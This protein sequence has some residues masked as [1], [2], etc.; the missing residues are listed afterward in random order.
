MTELSL[1]QQ[2]QHFIETKPDRIQ[3]WENGTPLQQMLARAAKTIAGAK[4]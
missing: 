1:E 3:Q 4:A 2:A